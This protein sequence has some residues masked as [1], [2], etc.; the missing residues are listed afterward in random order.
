MT[1]I[2]LFFMCLGMLLNGCAGPSKA[3]YKELLHQCRVHERE[4]VR[5][6]KE[7]AKK[8]EECVVVHRGEL[9]PQSKFVRD[10]LVCPI[11]LVPQQKAGEVGAGEA[12]F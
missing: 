6:D 1:I 9:V 3:R 10:A 4:Y 2:A 12:G 8:R 5:L 11:D 7:L